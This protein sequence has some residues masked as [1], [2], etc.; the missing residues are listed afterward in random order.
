MKTI[1]IL[2]FP[3]LAVNCNQNNNINT[4]GLN[5]NTCPKNH[6]NNIIPIIYGYPSEELF[7][8]ADSGLVQL[9]G[10]EISENAPN[11]YC[12]THNISF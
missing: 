7:A 11:W 6:T 1:F 9:G 8:K 5:D 2:L 3:F 10:C 12:K 4:D